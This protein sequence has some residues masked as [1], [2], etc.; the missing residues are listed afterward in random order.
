M[1]KA[2]ET[3]LDDNPSDWD[4]RLVYAD[5]LE[6]NGFADYACAQR[7]MGRKKRRPVLGTGSWNWWWLSTKYILREPEVVEHYHSCRITHK[8]FCLLTR[9]MEDRDI[10]YGK[11]YNSRLEAELDLTDALKKWKEG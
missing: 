10:R 2:F 11:T 9:S 7:W 3:A 8:F 4:T 1:N 6:E 5:W